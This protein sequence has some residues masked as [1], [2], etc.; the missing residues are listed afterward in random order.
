MSQG[1]FEDRNFAF[2]VADI[3]KMA[4]NATVKVILFFVVSIHVTEQDFF[5]FFT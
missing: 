2:V 3:F 5:H 4:N 1:N